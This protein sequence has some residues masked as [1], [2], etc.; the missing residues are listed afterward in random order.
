MLALMW[1]SLS[2]AEPSW[3]TV[4]THPYRIQVRKQEG[5]PVYEVW[6]EGRLNVAPQDIQSVVTDLNLLK[7]FMPYL[8]ESREL[9]PKGTPGRQ[10]MYG[11]LDLPVLSARDFIHQSWLDKDAK[12]DPN[13][14]F[15]NHWAALPDYLPRRAGTVRL[16]IS[17]GSWLVVPLPGGSSQV[18]YRFTA[19]PGG[20]IPAFVA[21]RTNVQG[22]VDT[23]RNVERE[24]QKRARE[25]LH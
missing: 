11:R 7:E 15:A 3:E 24:A 19:D 10:L 9:E 5:V 22:V 2:G 4:A 6:A 12:T 25:R 8:V 1:G 18:S 13:G 21:N 14:V 20:W 23:F 17:R 16:E